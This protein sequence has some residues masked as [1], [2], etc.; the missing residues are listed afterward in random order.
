MKGKD[1]EPVS[2]HMATVGRKNSFLTGRNHKKD[3]AQGG[4]AMCHEWLGVRGTMES[5][6]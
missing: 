4:A 6:K 2:K 1:N 5:Q 3:E